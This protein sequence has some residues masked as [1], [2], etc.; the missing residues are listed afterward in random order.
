MCVPVYDTHSRSSLSLSLSLSQGPH[1]KRLFG[2]RGDD[3]SA[4]LAGKSSAGE[5]H[6]AGARFVLAARPTDTQS[7]PVFPNLGG[8]QRAKGGCEASDFER[9]IDVRTLPQ[10]Q[11]VANAAAVRP[12]LTL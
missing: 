3:G 7:R 5:G 9:K 1:K 10:F 2:F 4:G 6:K 8:R 11:I 12:C